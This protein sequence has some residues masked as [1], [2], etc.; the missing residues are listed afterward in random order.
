VRSA[1]ILLAFLLIVVVFAPGFL[2]H[3]FLLGGLIARLI[4]LALFVWI[5]TECGAFF[6]AQGKLGPKIAPREPP[7][8]KPEPRI[9]ET[10]YCFLVWICRD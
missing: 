7:T 10:T 3:A 8:K 4:W 5:A 9:G 6:A 1:V 2:R